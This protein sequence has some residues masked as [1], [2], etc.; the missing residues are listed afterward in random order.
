MFDITKQFSKNMNK[1]TFISILCINFTN[2]FWKNFKKTQ[3]CHLY[4]A[5][6]KQKV[7]LNMAFS[8]DIQVDID[9]LVARG[10]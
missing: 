10:S 5:A 1:N 4:L 6:F 9:L 3:L 2:F 8:C 7:F